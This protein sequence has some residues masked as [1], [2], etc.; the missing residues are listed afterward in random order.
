[1]I[2]IQSPTGAKPIKNYII[3]MLEQSKTNMYQ[4]KITHFQE[5]SNLVGIFWF[6][7][8]SNL[9]NFALRNSIL[10]YTAFILLQ[11]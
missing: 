2:V 8:Y 4:T 7:V 5:V 3:S 6:P 10:Y 1:M 11:C 9:Y